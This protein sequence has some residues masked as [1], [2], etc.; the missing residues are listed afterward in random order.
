MDGYV[1]LIFSIVALALG[2]IAHHLARSAGSMLSLL[3]GFVLA[4]IG[5]LVL[6][7]VVPH[8]LDL[9]GW[10]A[11]AGALLGF[12]AP[13]LVEQ[14]LHHYAAKAH[15]AALLFAIAG[16][17]VHAFAD[18]LALAETVGSGGERDYS[19]LPAAVVL[20][21]LP[22]G[23]TIWLLLRPQYGQRLALTTLA[24][25]AAATVVGYELGEAAIA[26]VSDRTWG[27]FQALV[28]GSLMHVLVHRTPS[29]SA[30]RRL[31]T[32]VGVGIGMLLVGLITWR[33]GDAD[34]PLGLVAYALCAGLFLLYGVVRGSDRLCRL[35]DH[36]HSDSS[37][38]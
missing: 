35:F 34:G 11:I 33:E 8:S 31:P 12:L 37:D 14:R 18:G 27:L 30:G 25:L 38:P 15:T 29:S 20:H 23:A 26:E 24:I 22:V 19:M 6:L 7:D 16:I 5:G 36:Y 32:L 13:S 9:V 10:L 28:A 3:D 4:A 21:R 17:A 2:P 1:V